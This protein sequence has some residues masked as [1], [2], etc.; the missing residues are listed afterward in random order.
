M[1]LPDWAWGYRR[2]FSN[3]QALEELLDFHDD[4]H[5]NDI[6]TLGLNS[7]D[8]GSR[9]GHALY[10]CSQFCDDETGSGSQAGG[11]WG[12][13]LFPLIISNGIET[14]G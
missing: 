1:T 2:A 12:F 5:D 6:Y 11:L 13:V 4:F 10:F 14:P 3:Q 9:R 8:C 7:G